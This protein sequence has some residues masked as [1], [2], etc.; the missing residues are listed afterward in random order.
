[1]S[2]VQDL[3][4]SVYDIIH[5]GS[6]AVD[7]SDIIICKINKPVA[8]GFSMIQRAVRIPLQLVKIAVQHT[9]RPIQIIQQLVDLIVKCL[10]RH[11]DRF[12]FVHTD[13]R[14]H[15]TDNSSDI[16]ASVHFSR[17]R[18]ISQQTAL[19][20]CNASDIIA[21]MLIS[22]NAGIPA[23]G[24]YA[25]RIS[26]NASDIDIASQ[27]GIIRL[28]SIQNPFQSFAVP[29]FDSGTIVIDPCL[30]IACHNRAMVFTRNT[31]DTI[32]TVD[33]SIGVTV[34]DHSGTLV[35]TGDAS[36]RILP[37]YNAYKLTVHQDSSVDTTDATDT[38]LLI[39]GFDHT[40]NR[41][42]L[43]D[44]RFF[45]MA[46]K[47]VRIAFSGQSKAGD[48]ISF[49][50]KRSGKNLNR[51]KLDSFQRNIPAQLDPDV[52]GPGIHLA[53]LCQFL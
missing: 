12:G 45:H 26:C 7:R 6:N 28:R 37:F 29:F 27:S 24:D 4:Q 36:D 42:V 44:C 5:I 43:N 25:V 40:R 23:I 39:F 50:V 13:K 9:L 8:D 32:R 10:D 53:V 15:L 46:E 2:M 3:R 18:A 11:R 21:D 16:L 19:A 49:S 14:F 35:L 17:I 33:T 34:T 38:F 48:R 22:H 52:R 51:F 41:Q 20:S 1:M 31:S 47:S 30:I